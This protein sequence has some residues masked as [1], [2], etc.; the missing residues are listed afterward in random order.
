MSQCSH[1][2]PKLISG[3]LRASVR[4]AG[5]EHQTNWNNT[6]SE[7]FSSLGYFSVTF[8]STELVYILPPNL[9]RKP[10][11]AVQVNTL[12]SVNSWTE[13]MGSKRD[14]S[15]ALGNAPP[16][17]ITLVFIQ[18]VQEARFLVYSRQ[19]KSMWPL[20][21]SSPTWNQ[22]GLLVPLQE[23]VWVKKTWARL[24][25]RLLIWKIGLTVL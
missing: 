21:G 10:F 13:R 3:S 22:S 6:W 17:Q 23:S 15:L 11:C 16:A 7:M 19:S 20:Y 18:R 9:G 8:F 24:L 1:V 4:L 14:A 25:K 12:T 5:L 2:H